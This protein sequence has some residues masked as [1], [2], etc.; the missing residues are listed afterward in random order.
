MIWRLSQPFPDL[1]GTPRS[2]HHLKNN[3]QYIRI[4]K[5]IEIFSSSDVLVIGRPVQTSP[6]FSEQRLLSPTY[7]F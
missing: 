5:M 1:I 6:C 3:V 4:N 7:I 2:L